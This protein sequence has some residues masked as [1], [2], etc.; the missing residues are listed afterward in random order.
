MKFALVNDLEQSRLNET[1]VGIGSL[2]QCVKLFESEEAATAYAA[3]LI[4]EHAS[5]LELKDSDSDSEVLFAFQY[6][7]GGL[8]WF[9]VFPVAE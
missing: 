4:R 6:S 7:L 1:D 3:K 2:Q 5:E 9:H 8:E